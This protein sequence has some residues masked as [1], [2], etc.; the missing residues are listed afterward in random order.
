MNKITKHL[1]PGEETNQN[2]IL[3]LTEDRD[4]LSLRTDIIKINP[5]IIDN[6]TP[7]KAI[8]I[9]GSYQRYKKRNNKENNFLRPPIKITNTT[10]GEKTIWI[11][12][13]SEK[14]IKEQ[15]KRTGGNKIIVG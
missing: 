12:E 11:T 1:R 3:T 6:R 4:K 7:E 2:I 15:E 10:K 5:R 9:F 14:I 13:I 8:K